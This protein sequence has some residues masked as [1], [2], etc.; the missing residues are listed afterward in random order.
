MGRTKD[1]EAV[2]RITHVHVRLKRDLGGR[3]V[4]FRAEEEGRLRVEPGH[5]GPQLSR[6]K[7]VARLA[8]NFAGNCMPD[9]DSEIS[10]SS[11]GA[12]LA[13]RTVAL[14]TVTSL[15][16]PDLCY[17]HRRFEQRPLVGGHSALFQGLGVGGGGGA[18][19]DAVAGGSTAV[20]QQAGCYHHVIGLDVSS[21]ATV[22]TYVADLAAAAAP[23]GTLAMGN[24]VVCGGT[25]CSWDALRR[26]EDARARQFHGDA[27]CAEGQLQPHVQQLRGYVY[28]GSAA[29]EEAMRSED[30]E[31]ASSSTAPRG[32]FLGP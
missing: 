7:H 25:Y 5:D 14:S 18:E 4:L 22:S 12:A 19:G 21:P 20:A 32:R 31:E 10:D 8:R 9:G 6:A 27:N 1:L 17:L 30:E 3:A 13:A 29:T 15:G 26:Q 24:W 28:Q 11:F 16:P 2:D 23:A